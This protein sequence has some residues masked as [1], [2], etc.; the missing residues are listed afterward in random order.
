MEN[1]QTTESLFNLKH[2][3]GI[4]IWHWVTFALFTATIITVL[5]A[6][7]LF[8]TRSNISMVQDQVKE[9][10]GTVTMDQAKTVAHEYNDK[11]WNTHKIIGYFL[12]FALLSRMIIEV[13]NSKEEKLL[14]RI[15]LA[16]QLSKNKTSRNNDSQHYLMVKYGYLVFYLLFLIMACTGLILAYEDTE[17]LKPFQQTARSIHEFVQYC[18]YGYI[19]FHLVGVIRADVTENPGIVSRMI[20]KG[21]R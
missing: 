15:K 21:N 5:L 12:C 6:N 16:A 4:R 8:D 19:V 7:T 17:F 14:T 3:L 18:I 9:K 11:L 20:N 2:S 10:G 1:F 13:T